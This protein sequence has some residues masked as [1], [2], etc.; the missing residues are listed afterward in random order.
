FASAAILMGIAR[1]GEYSASLMIEAL[2]TI[3]AFAVVLPLYG[4]KYA[5][6]ICSI[7]I[8][9]NRCVN[10]SRIFTKEFQLAQIPFLW[11]VYWLPLVFGAA[12]LA[13][14]WSIKRAWIPGENVREL[15]AIGLGNAMF[16]G[17]ASFFF[18][19]EP[20]HRS[21]LIE[22]LRGRYR[23]YIRIFARA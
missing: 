9:L 23:A 10:L 12:D 1:Y 13:I 6:A 14:L 20:Y 8:A 15:V 16:L 2:T 18:M 21:L 4:L 17:V 7:M 3:A 19:L 5:I 22:N 11:R